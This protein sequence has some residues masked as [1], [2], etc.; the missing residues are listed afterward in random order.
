MK[1]SCLALMIILLCQCR[2]VYQS[3]FQSPDTGY[4]VVEGF[5]AYG[6]ETTILLSRTSAL[7]DRGMVPEKQ[8]VVQVEGQ[9]NSVYALNEQSPGKYNAPTL[10][11]SVNTTYRLRI[12]TQSNK[13]YLS[14]FTP[15]IIT[16]AIDSISWERKNGVDIYIHSHDPLNIS[17]YYKWDYEETWSFHSKYHT[18]ATF[19]YELL[20]NGEKYYTGINYFDPITKRNNDSLFYCWGSKV[21]AQLLMGTTTPLSSN[22]VYQP[23]RHHDENAWEL[24]ELYAIE[25]KQYGLSKEAYEF[26]K[27]MKKNTESLGS[28]FDA[29]PSELKGN[30]TCTTNP[31]EQVL[32]FVETCSEETKRIFIRN[33]DLPGW[34]FIM[35]CVDPNPPAGLNTPLD[36]LYNGVV[37]GNLPTEPLLDK[38]GNISGFAA[39]DRNCVDCRLRGSPLKPAFWP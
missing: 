7:S 33:Q 26:F 1:K 20:P 38:Y 5:I 4:L 39:A 30:I 13:E 14:E 2:E 34:N 36:V 19:T 11:L 31:D 23:I 8:A 25:V 37:K 32:G 17:Q 9:D 15:V 29:Q 28:I 22:V 24:N 18:N 27:K 3:K 10:P 35:V 21:P 6:K 16:P 12:G